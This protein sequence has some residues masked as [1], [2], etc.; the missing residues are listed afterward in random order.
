MTQERRTMGKIKA[1]EA[2]HDQLKSQPMTVKELSQATGYTERTT[3][4]YVRDLIS[5]GVV[6]IHDRIGRQDR[7]V[8]TEKTVIPQMPTPV[9]FV[10]PGTIVNQVASRGSRKKSRLEILAAKWDYAFVALFNQ[11]K[12]AVD[13]GKFSDEKAKDLE[14]YFRQFRNEL[15]VRLRV[16][17]YILASDQYWTL[18]GL[19]SF[20][21]DAAWPNIRIEQAWANVLNWESPVADDSGE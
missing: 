18:E 1:L 21:T 16:I 12:I 7:Y 3:Y 11:A 17:N 2:V 19:Q 6:K 15:E 13:E 5:D 8:A 4:N 10:H 14:T 9:G 20:A